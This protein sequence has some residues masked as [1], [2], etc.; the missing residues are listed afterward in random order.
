ML[1][2]AVIPARWWSKWI[3]LKNL[4]SLG[5]KPL[6]Y[7]TILAA[8]ESNSFDYICVS[9]DD[10]DILEFSSQFSWID[11]IKRPKELS[12]DTSLSIDVVVHSIEQYINKWIIP[13]LV[14]LLQPTSPFRNANNIREACD[15][16]RKS[17]H[18][19]SL[20][21]VCQ[22]RKHPYKSFL[23][24]E[25]TLIPLFWEEYLSMPRQGLPFILD[26]N[27]AIYINNYSDLLKYRSFFVPPTI[28]YVMDDFSS[29]DIDS[30]I[31]LDY[32]NFLIT[33]VVS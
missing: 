21:S 22:S 19:R 3:P 33:K 15:L 14:T 2:I 20:M 12:Q 24:S 25:N 1:N 8:I 18:Y 27:G 26:Q 5:G 31:D 32:W 4:A 10:K 17:Q 16:F 29:I 30:P 11:I 7:Y 13:G 23:T 28:P 6:I 9:S